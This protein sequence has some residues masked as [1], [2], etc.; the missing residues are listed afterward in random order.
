MGPAGVRKEQSS[1]V[2]L[3][4][5]MTSGLLWALCRPAKR[6]QLHPMPMPSVESSWG[7]STVA[8][9]KLQTVSL[10]LLWARLLFLLPAGQ[11]SVASPG[12]PVYKGE[13]P[14]FLDWARIVMAERRKHLGNIPW[15]LKELLE[16]DGRQRDGKFWKKLGVESNQCRWNHGS[17][18]K[19]LLLEPQFCHV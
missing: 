15:A 8:G 2:R 1:G 9:G 19:F 17:S 5:S 7:W 18:I 11:I 14:A 12:Q 6:Q 3:P 13:V 10:C 4:V 16:M